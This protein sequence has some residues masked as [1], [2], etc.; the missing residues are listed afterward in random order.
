[1]QINTSTTDNDGKTKTVVLEKRVE[2][3]KKQV[4]VNGKEITTTDGALSAEVQEEL[5][6][7]GVELVDL[8]DPNTVESNGC[9]VRILRLQHNGVAN[10]ELQEMMTDIETATED[11]INAAMEEGGS[12]AFA[13]KM[14]AVERDG[15]EDAKSMTIER[16][17]ENGKEQLVINGKSIDISNGVMPD[18]AAVKEMVEKLAAGADAKSMVLQWKSNRR[19]PAAPTAPNAPTPPN[20]PDD[21]PA[22]PAVP[23]MKFFDINNSN[24]RFS[25]NKR[26]MAENRQEIKE[27]CR[28]MA[29][30]CKDMAEKCKDM[31]AKMNAGCKM[32]TFNYDYNINMDTT[33]SGVFVMEFGDDEEGKNNVIVQR[34]SADNMDELQGLLPVPDEAL[35]TNR[36]YQVIIIE[37]KGGDDAEAEEEGSVEPQ[38]VEPVVPQQSMEKTQVEPIPPTDIDVQTEYF[39]VFPN[40]TQGILNISIALQ[41]PGALTLTVTDMLGNQVYR[42]VVDN[43][44]AKQQLYRQ[45][46]LADKAKGTYIVHIESNGHS[47]SRQVV[48]Q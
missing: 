19:A 30:K 28:E 15:K 39:N 2:N 37:C 16:V 25:C 24:M 48:V 1:M 26:A 27:K 11:E 8:D 36:R 44:D 47:L 34:F 46:N 40:P 29:E 14:F 7:L 23:M 13:M 35:S 17:M 42:E 33:A 3:G 45:V 32:F 6:R 20:A 9:K 10:Q 5:D 38:Q 21:V 41:Q 22:P 31:S 43:Y 4:F 18:D 12:T